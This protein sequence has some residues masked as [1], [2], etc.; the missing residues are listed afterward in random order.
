[1]PDL[2]S[3]MTT[4]LS[5]FIRLLEVRA[6]HFEFSEICGVVESALRSPNNF[7]LHQLIK[8]TKPFFMAFECKEF[9]RLSE[10][11]DHA[12]ES[13]SKVEERNIKAYCAIFR[14]DI[15]AWKDALKYGEEHEFWVESTRVYGFG[16]DTAQFYIEYPDK[17]G[18]DPIYDPSIPVLDAFMA[19][20]EARSTVMELNFLGSFVGSYMSKVYKTQKRKLSDK[21]ERRIMALHRDYG[22]E[23]FP[24]V[25]SWMK[26][27]L[28]A[29]DLDAMETLHGYMSHY[30]HDFAVEK[31][32][33]EAYKVKFDEEVE[34][35]QEKRGLD[36]FGPFWKETSETLGFGYHTVEAH[37]EC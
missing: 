24:E 19:L 1:M 9:E 21:E 13:C 20:L 7:H 37:F 28:L 3:G 15:E 32:H 5:A 34:Y 30:E 36:E 25:I 16:R 18:P 26:P 31:R 4:R 8:W 17:L 6:T 11:L 35:W 23:M 22:F 10:Y 29:L 33:F 27:H 14:R 2:D 12:G